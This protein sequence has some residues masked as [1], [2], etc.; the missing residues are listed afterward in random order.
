MKLPQLHLLFPPPPLKCGHHLKKL[1]NLASFFHAYIISNKGFLSPSPKLYSLALANRSAALLR[2]GLFSDALDD[3]D[4]A[5]AV[6][7]HPKP[8]KLEERRGKCV[9]A[10]RT[11]ST[12]NGTHD[13]TFM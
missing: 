12:Q 6:G 7:S 10:M 9:E 13:Y 4:A 3:L 8:D 11:V 1:P 5:L 2:V